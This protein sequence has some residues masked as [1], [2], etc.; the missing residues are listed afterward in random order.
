M[1]QEIQWNSSLNI[2]F[3]HFERAF[4]S[5]HRETLWNII[6]SFGISPKLARMVKE[7][8]HGSQC[9][10][11]DGAGQIK[12]ICLLYDCLDYDKNTRGSH[13][14]FQMETVVKQR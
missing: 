12:C 3:V 10:V 4:D 13:H 6:E 7:M 9:A 1:E 14:S 8:F 11:L 2:C 5:I